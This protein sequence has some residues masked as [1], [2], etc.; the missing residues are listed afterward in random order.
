MRLSLATIA[1]ILPF[2]VAAAPTPRSA[3]GV[4]LPLK[5]SVVS[6]SL[7]TLKDEITFVMNKNAL[8]FTNFAANTGS[9][10]ALAAK[11]PSH[12][13]AT[14]P[15][16]T[17]A[18]GALQSVHNSI[19]YATVAVGTPAQYYAVSVDTASADLVLPGSECTTCDGHVTYD[20]TYSSTSKSKDHGFSI[21]DVA[22]GSLYTDDLSILGLK[23]N[24][25]TIGVAEAY[26]T[27]YHV[28]NFPAD[29]ILGLAFGSI[30]SFNSS[31]PFQTLVTEGQIASKQF[32]LRLSDP[33]ELT[34][35]GIDAT[36]YTGEVTYVPV[37]KQGFWQISVD[38]LTSSS[39]SKP[40][41]S[42]FDAIVDSSASFILGPA[43]AVSAFYSGVSGATDN[44]DGTYTV[45]CDAALSGSI[46]LGGT[47]FALAADTLVLESDESGTCVGAVAAN[48][49]AAHDYWVLGDAFL[50]NVY[51]VFDFEKPQVGFAT[52]A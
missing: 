15:A 20:P 45:A 11:D 51:S 2:F 27:P 21:P 40:V 19:W 37:M 47:S 22:A 18:T 39:S 38:S 14:A 36:A 33:A 41:A 7:D 17:M 30:S 23:A 8:G 34:V 28:D 6:M 42:S 4:K 32:G 43:D 24:G 31:S 1:A 10:H 52:L 13:L 44:G 3:A 49:N 9:V 29:G 16:P 12:T 5:K 50:R 46:T 35:G 26:H 25:Q 48:Q